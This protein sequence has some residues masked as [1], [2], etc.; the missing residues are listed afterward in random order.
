MKKALSV[1]VFFL[2][3]WLCIIPSYAGSTVKQPIMHPFDGD[4]LYVG[5]SGS[6]NYSTIQD[7]LN[8]AS[9]GDIIYIF[10][11]LYEEN[12]I[13]DTSV[14]LVGENRNTTII[15]GCRNDNVMSIYSDDV[16]VEE[17]TIQN[18]KNDFYHSG[19]KITDAYNVSIINNNIQNNHGFGISIHDAIDAEI[20]IEGNL[21]NNNSYGIYIIESS[22]FDISSN[23]ILNNSDGIY[24]VQSNN[25]KFINNTIHNYG[26]GIHISNSFDIIIYQNLIIDNSNGIY[27]YDSTNIII[28]GNIVKENRWYGIWF[29]DSS[30][31][32]V[33][34]NTIY[35]NVD[36]G[37][38][39][40]NSSDNFIDE[41]LI[42][43][44][45]DGVYLERSSRNIIENNNFKNYKLN[46][47]FVASS[48]SQCL[49]RWHNNYWDRAHFLPHPIL[50]KIKFENYMFSWFNVD[51]NPLKEPYESN[52]FELISFDNSILYVGGSGPGNYSHIQDAIDDADYNDTV[53][54]YNSTYSEKIIINKPLHLIGE[55]KNF[56]ILEG[57]GLNDI[58]TIHSSY[59]EVEGFTLQNGHFS[60]LIKKSS[61][62][63]IKDTIIVNS[64]QGISVQN[65]CSNITITK[66]TFDYNQ[67]GIRLYSS[68][69]VTVNY[70]NFQSYKLN[71][72]FTGTSLLHCKNS[73]RYNYWGASK[74]LPCII[75][76]KIRIGNYPLLCLN[77]DW[78]PLDSNYQGSI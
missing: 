74:T 59:V 33:S 75:F 65:D 49:N 37:V 41:N 64:L 70:N 2:F 16:K 6:G 46:A 20:L 10:S 61:N 53:Y 60:I 28:S 30:E 73:W 8:N 34:E 57:N 68:S 4:T 76:G 78:H 5:G 71:A 3:I 21:I 63:L 14:I 27:N 18:A 47:Y 66:N 36:I 32:A 45:D 19:I 23:S 24:V 11:G 44:N 67:Y 48:V 51:W 38:F 29:R 40:D 31:S 42:F 62:I 13:I 22:N 50:G 15:D 26:L 35:K 43:D 56:T 77:I 1:A 9:N 39:F 25:I 54:V 72:F 7:A 69:Y 52:N 17:I 58:I 12:I 55:N